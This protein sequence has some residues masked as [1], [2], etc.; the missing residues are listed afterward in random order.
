MSKWS[1]ADEWKRLVSGESCPICLN[2]KP[3]NIIAELGVTYLTAGERTSIKGACALFSKKH[4]VELYELSAEE[5]TVFMH[6]A[7]KASKAIHEATGAVKMNYEIHGNTIP[8]L[9]MHLFPRYVGDMFE[10]QPINPRIITPPAYA[11]GEFADFVL[12]IKRKLKQ[13]GQDE[14]SEK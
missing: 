3:T 10:N 4:V 1:D 7:Q 6:D 8:H 2:G 9:H 14:L 12:E 5:I 11:E 13:D